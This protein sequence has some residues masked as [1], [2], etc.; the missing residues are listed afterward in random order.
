MSFAKRHDARGD[1]AKATFL[2]S[3]LALAATGCAAASG[4]R[5][6][7]RPVP[8]I[9]R[10]PGYELPPSGSATVAGKPVSGLV[11]KRGRTARFGTHLEVF[12][13]GLDVM[14]PAGIGVAPPRRRA[15]AYV[16]AGRCEYPARTLE[17]T[18]LIEIDTGRKLTLGQ[19]FD[20]WGQPL[21]P[22][23]LLGFRPRRGRSVAAFVNGRRWRGDPRGIPLERH[24]A[25]VVEVGGYFPPTRKYLFPNGL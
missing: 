1:S 16:A 3:V 7:D 6:P 23:A 18:G 21:G 25:V 4:Q 17:P 12:A 5:P 15:G 24:A 9:G 13:N 10:G 14:V 11:C 19:F 8:H 22:R 20:L 2:L